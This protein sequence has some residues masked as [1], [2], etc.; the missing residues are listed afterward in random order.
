MLV[1]SRKLGERL[2]IDESI[3]VTV[4]KVGRGKVRLG[5][6]A[7]PHVRVLRQ[8]LR[9]FASRGEPAAAGPQEECR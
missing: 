7:P 1:L 9:A 8:E 4:V 5:V 2:V 6:E 3:V